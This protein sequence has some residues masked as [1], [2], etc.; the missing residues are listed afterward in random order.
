MK[1]IV[2][3]IIAIPLVLIGLWLVV[4][5]E[6]L[7]VRHLEDALGRHGMKL[8]ITG[9]SKGLFY[10]FSIGETR[11]STGKDLPVI[12]VNDLHAG[13]DFLSLFKFKPQLDL[14]G[15]VYD[16]MVYGV[17]GQGGRSVT[18]NGSGI[19]MNGIP[20]LER[21]GVRGNGKLDFDLHLL[22]DIGEAKFSIREA[23]FAG[24]FFG[25]DFLPLDL[26]Q[27]AR[28]IITIEKT[29]TIKS[30]T[31]EGRGLYARVNGN[32]VGKSLRMKIELMIDSS[33]ELQPLLA[34]N[35]EPYRVSPGCYVINFSYIF[36]AG[37][38]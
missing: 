15:N 6:A 28:G 18:V 20:A 32:I 19:N 29:I 23:R 30:L 35:L 33:F 11:V 26:F 34:K 31:L 8:Q 36:P 7:L 24:D 2:I 37:Q 16:G 21:F 10:N 13:I 27:S 38:K 5:P 4:V 22:D 9:F 12:S 14:S 25:V 17:I 1:K 3:A